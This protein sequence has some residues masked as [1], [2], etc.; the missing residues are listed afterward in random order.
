MSQ[1]LLEIG[2]MVVKRAEELGA[3]Q[4]EAYVAA[5]RSFTI[6]V[7]NN[8][9]KSASE[10]RNAGCG[11]RSVIKKG[12]IG[13]AYV[14]TIQ[15]EDLLEAVSRSVELAK[16]SVPDPDF[17]ALPS[18]SG[19][20]P[21][22]AGLF[23]PAIKNLSSEEAAELIMRTVDATNEAVGT[24]K[25]AVEAQLNASAG[26]KAIV[27]SLDISRSVETA[28][29]FIY[30]YP[31]VKDG[32]DQTSSYEFQVSRSRK[33]IDPEWIGSTAG[34]TAVN[35]LG[36]RTIEGGDMPIILTP[37]AVSTIIGGGFGGAINAEEI[38]YGRSYI[39]DALGESIASKELSIIDDSHIAGGIGSRSFDAEGV[40]TQ[41]T[42]ILHCGVLK[43]ILH[44]SYT[45]NKDQV[46]NTG[47]ASRASYSGLPLISPSNF[48]IE[49][50]KGTLDDLVSEVKKGILFRYTGD[51][52]NMTT[53]D[54]SA[55][56]LEGHYIKDGAIEHSVKNTLVGINM[57][58]LLQRVHRVGADVRVTS[59][60]VTPSIV[61]E[62]AKVTSG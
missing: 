21:T 20:Y 58:D 7:E 25:T 9:I 32:N 2:A 26:T 52:P 53:G 28:S 24:K 54:L 36:G 60:V 61:I 49:P 57:R 62:S 48:V 27:N 13:F 56:V 29:M 34:R 16:A 43:N 6:D 51:R 39:A 33:S 55:M 1:N 5:S 11:I 45:A 22:V 19:N 23:D 4:A 37:L 46:E 8:A 30:S 14:T 10:K 12:R 3:S 35:S 15:D 17:V 41:R 38:Q 18:Y 59:T 40:P 44:N 47:N 31:T 42:Q 50:G